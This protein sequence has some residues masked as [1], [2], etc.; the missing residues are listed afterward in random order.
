MN[1]P[2]VECLGRGVAV[3]AFPPPG[4]R[5]RFGRRLLAGSEQRL[6]VDEASGAE[7]ECKSTSCNGTTRTS[8][9]PLGSADVGGGTERHSLYSGQAGGLC[10]DYC[11]GVPLGM[12]PG[13]L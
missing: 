13:P 3:A 6:V 7:S 1:A 5:G 2:E 10:K 8:G 9:R 12:P 4:S 11:R